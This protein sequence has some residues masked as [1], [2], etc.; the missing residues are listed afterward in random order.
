METTR[1]HRCLIQLYKFIH[2]PPVGWVANMAFAML[3]NKYQNEYLELL[4]EYSVER[5]EQERLRIKN[6]KEELKIFNEELRR[7]EEK[8]K[9]NWLNA[10]GKA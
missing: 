4:K 3:Q 7:K 8:L 5:Y 6:R 2:K 9:Q 10:G 1:V